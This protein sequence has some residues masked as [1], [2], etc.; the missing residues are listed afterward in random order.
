MGAKEGAFFQEIKGD[1]ETLK[2][3]FGIDNA[4]PPY[5]VVAQILWYLVLFGAV[6]GSI[7]RKKADQR[8]AAIA[9]ALLALSVFL[10]VFECRARYLFLYAPS[11]VILASVGWHFL[12]QKMSG[13]AT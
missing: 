4:D 8:V 6:L 13:K 7:P 2:W 1:N 3:F 9:I 11:F 12:T 10:M 5:D